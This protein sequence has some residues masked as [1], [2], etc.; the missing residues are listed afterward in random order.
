[1]ITQLEKL[2]QLIQDPAATAEQRMAELLAASDSVSLVMVP[3]KEE[4]EPCREFN[5]S[6]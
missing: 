2:A 3:Q 4:D 1:M 6:W 5:T